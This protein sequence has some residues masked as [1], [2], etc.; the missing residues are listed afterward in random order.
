MTVL[1]LGNNLPFFTSLILQ[2]VNKYPSL[3]I[4]SLIAYELCQMNQKALLYDKPNS[5][6]Y[7]YITNLTSSLFH[8]PDHSSVHSFLEDNS[9]I[10]A[11]DLFAVILRR[12]NVSLVPEWVPR[13][14]QVRFRII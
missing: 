11:A 1:C 7:S 12:M 6:D 14:M 2:W 5:L 8:C 4:E 3:W 10:T 13:L 9:K